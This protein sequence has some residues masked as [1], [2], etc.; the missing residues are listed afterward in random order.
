MNLRTELGGTIFK[1]S[2]GLQ[3]A[4]PLFFLGMQG[5]ALKTALTIIDNKSVN[6]LSPLPF[7]SLFVNCV[8]WS[9]YGL[10]KSDN[11]VLIPNVIGI[12]VGFFCSFSYQVLFA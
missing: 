7:V 6:Q 1:V 10:L 8:V 4:G 12:F 3:V 11:T 9:M 5:S 2:D